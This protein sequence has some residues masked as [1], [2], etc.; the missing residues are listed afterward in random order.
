VIFFYAKIRGH[1]CSYGRIG[2][3]KNH[4]DELNETPMVGWDL[5]RVVSLSRWGVMSGYL[6]EEEAWTWIM[7]AARKIQASFGSWEELGDDY[8]LGR[9]FWSSRKM[10]KDG[11]RFR[12]G[13]YRLI[14]DPR[15]PWVESDWNL[16]LG[17]SAEPLAAG[18]EEIPQTAR[19]FEA[20]MHAQEGEY[21]CAVKSLEQS[22]QED[23]ELYK[24]FACWKLAQIYEYGRTGVQKDM[25][26]ANRFYRKGASFG[27]PDCITE[28]G[29]IENE[30]KE[31]EKALRLWEAA[32]ERGSLYALN[33]LGI[34][35]EKGD[36]VEK[37]VQHAMELYEKA[38][39]WG[40]PSAKNN[41][42]WLMYK[43]PEFWDADRA[44]SLAYAATNHQKVWC[45]Y[46]T[47]LKVLIQAERYPE[48]L[49]AWEKLS[50]FVKRD[51]N[52][53]DDLALPEWFKKERELILEKMKAQS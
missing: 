39:R 2:F 8:L 23:R 4:A 49:K 20:I 30:N 11:Y 1:F 50:E 43:N 28:M 7:P 14:S 26:Q 35:Y 51:A 46:D 42:A 53:W 13:I 15:S 37:D 38:A 45:N 3:V 25:E 47:L 33:N 52:N 22:I 19:F 31:Y 24:G 21:V 9:S 36:G 18:M 29:H 27:N 10:R 17:G 32:A 12:Q 34:R 40:L 41:L 44:V 48:A 16:E 6:S 5:A